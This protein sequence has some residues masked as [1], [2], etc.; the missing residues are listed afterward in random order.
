MTEPMRPRHRTVD[1]V[2]AI[3]ELVARSEGLTLT[4]IAQG[5]DYPLSTTQGLVNGLTAT[6]YLDERDKRYTLGMAP[7]LINAM[8]GRRPIE[9]VNQSEI[10]AIF[11]ETGLVTVLAIAVDERVFYLHHAAEGM[12]YRYLTENFLPRSLLRTSS[13]WVLLAGMERRDLWSYL[14]T[15]PEEQEGYVEAFLAAAGDIADTGV[16]ASPAVAE[17]GVDGVSVAVQQNGRTVAAVGVIGSHEEIAARREELVEVLL[18]R[19]RGWEAA[20]G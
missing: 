15:R 12:S 18:R 17:R 8:A 5:L 3:L 4:D 10:D 6:G 11:A 9:V 7:Y 20:A 13:G 19:R 2:A 16:C 14:R 1:R